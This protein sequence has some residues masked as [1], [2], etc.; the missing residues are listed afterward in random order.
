MK[1]STREDIGADLE[2]VFA[3]ISDFDNFER[4]ALR[5]GAE[6]TRLDS[7]PVPGRG[8][9]WDAKFSFRKRERSAQMEI[10]EYDPPNGLI[11]ASKVSGIN[12]LVV[13]ELVA[14][15]RNRTRM[16]LSIDLTPKTIPA[17]LLLQSMKLARSGMNKRLEKRIAAFA[18]Q[19][20][21][22]A[23]A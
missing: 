4:A 7:L 18:E 21:D 15:S 20:E 13:V 1:F 23:N 6:V 19:I 17:R 10:T 22:G 12:T 14:L 16:N 8:M 11:L 5:R 3:A 9:S 2:T